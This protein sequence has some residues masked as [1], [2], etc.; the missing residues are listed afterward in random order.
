MGYFNTNYYGIA[1]VTYL[2]FVVIKIK[3]VAKT[4]KALKRNLFVTFRIKFTF[5]HEFLINYNRQFFWKLKVLT[6]YL[7]LITTEL[8][9]H[10]L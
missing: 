4:L 2:N 7:T 5:N 10:I 8:L 1:N 9:Q 6:T 3:Y